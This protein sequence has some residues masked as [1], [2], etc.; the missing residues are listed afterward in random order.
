MKQ[1]WCCVDHNFILYRL[2]RRCSDTK[3]NIQFILFILTSFYSMINTLYIGASLIHMRDCSALVLYRYNSRSPF[4]PKYNFL[5][6]ELSHLV[7]F[8]LWY[9]AQNCSAALKVKTSK[10]RENYWRVPKSNEI[11][12]LSY[13]GKN[14]YRS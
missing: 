3:Y 9:N 6:K 8:I 13:K 7:Y 4:I 10:K 14:W 5:G 1:I 2:S 12:T 11:Q